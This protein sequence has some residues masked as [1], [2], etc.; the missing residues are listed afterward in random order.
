MATPETSVVWKEC[1]RSFNRRAATIYLILF[2]ASAPLGIAVRFLTDFGWMESLLIGFFT[3]YVPVAAYLLVKRRRDGVK[4]RGEIIWDFGRRPGSEVWGILAYLGLF[5]L[6]MMLIANL[7]QLNEGKEITLIITIY[8]F[9]GWASTFKNSSGKL[10][11][12][13][14]GIWAYLRLLPWDALEYFEWKESDEWKHSAL[15]LKYRSPK[16]GPM[17]EI[18]II[19]DK[20][21][22]E[23]EELLRQHLQ[24]P[25]AEIEESVDA[26]AQTNS[27]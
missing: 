1:G 18:L 12:C 19:P 2:A 13:T 9:A 6:I 11:F 27:A 15:W 22:D 3:V 10:L 25:T 26:K 4:Q 24:M 20:S 14:N 17:R 8:V 21:K 5:L 23:V 7:V 16:F